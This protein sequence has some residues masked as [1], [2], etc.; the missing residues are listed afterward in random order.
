MCAGCSHSV[1]SSSA[2]TQSSAAAKAVTLDDLMSAPVPSLCKHDSGNLVNGT[3]PEQQSSPGS[4]SI[5]TKE[6]KE[7]WVA[8]GDLTGDGVDD[9]AL[10]TACNAGGVGWPATVQ[11]YTAGPTRLGGVDLGDVT[12]GGR[13]TVT[14]ISIANGVVHVEWIT[15][16][17]NDAACCGT[18]LMA[19]DLRVSGD[20]VVPENVRQTN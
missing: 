3:L 16:G 8:F 4:V 17:P 15:Q 1:P 20:Q 14:G 6:S 11:L 9:G 2:G 18:V 7:P 12:K 5:A 10:V 13:E 19:G